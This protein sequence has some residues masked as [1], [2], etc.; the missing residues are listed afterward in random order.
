MSIL[1][2][3]EHTYWP[4]RSTWNKTVQIP[5]EHDECKT[6]WQYC[7]LKPEIRPYL[8]KIPNEGIRKLSFAK[9][10]K[11]EGWSAGYPDYLLPIP[12]NNWHSLWIEMK[13]SKTS[14][15]RKGKAQVEWIEKLR[16]QRHYAVF[17]YGAD[18]AIRVI[19][20]YMTNKI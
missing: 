11:A 9:K 1:E 10:L 12:N 20:R 8:I 7:Q 17:C 6:F 2:L 19:D 18:H 15:S 13:R 4:I 16:S 14:S 3:F 5:S